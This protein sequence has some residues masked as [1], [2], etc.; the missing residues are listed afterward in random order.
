MAIK[1]TNAEDKNKAKDRFLSALRMPYEGVFSKMAKRARYRGRLK[2]YFQ[3][4]IEAIVH[5][6]K[7][8]QVISADPIPIT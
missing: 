3:A 2:V 1:K 7:R 6:F 5:N 8:L 4:L